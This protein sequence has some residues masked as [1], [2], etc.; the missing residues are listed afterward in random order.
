M[1]K[2][3]FCDWDGVLITV[4]SMIYNNRMKLLGLSS[5]PSDQA[6]C[7]IASSNLEYILEECPDVFVV[8]SSTWR[9]GKT[10]KS[11][12]KMFKMNHI[13][14]DRMIGTTPEIKGEY[15]GA[16]IEA[17]L[18]EHPEVTDFAIIDDENDMDPYMD[19][20]VQTDSRNGLTFSDAE[21]VIELLGGKSEEKD[22]QEN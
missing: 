12:Q 19:R 8:V 10:L 13:L 22:D 20:L 2:A 16:E 1:S 3:I 7:P 5:I 11:L 14:A 9:K 4:G 18:K 17:Y 6:F 21:R 15:R